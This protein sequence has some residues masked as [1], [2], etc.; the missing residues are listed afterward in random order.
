MELWQECVKWLKAVGVLDEHF[1]FQKLEEF[2]VF[3]GDGVLLCRLAHQLDEGSIDETQIISANSAN[4]QVRAVSF[5][6]NLVFGFRLLST[7]TLLS[8]KSF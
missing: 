6:Y 3:L 5:V 1:V 4:S 2:A 7:V 8:Q